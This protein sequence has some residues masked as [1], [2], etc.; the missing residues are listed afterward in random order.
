MIIDYQVSPFVSSIT[1]NATSPTGLTIV[2]EPFPFQYLGC[3][4]MAAYSSNSLVDAGIYAM[5]LLR[6]KVFYSGNNWVFFPMLVSAIVIWSVKCVGNV[7]GMSLA[8]KMYANNQLFASFRVTDIEQFQNLMYAIA[9]SAEAIY[10]FTSSALFLAALAKG[11]AMS[12]RELIHELFVKREGIRLLLVPI[13]NFIM[14]GF[15]VYA[16]VNGGV[17]TF[18]TRTG[19]YIASYGYALEFSTFLQTSYVSTKGI[20]ET[21]KSKRGLSSSSRNGDSSRASDRTHYNT[22]RQQLV[23][24]GPTKA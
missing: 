12:K 20:V 5:A 18:V 21:Q 3:V 11:L 9:Q 13:A 19:F 10:F 6:L 15:A 17:H 7:I 24:F 14:A 23:M 8:Y 22:D 1:P 16:Y 4:F 2:P